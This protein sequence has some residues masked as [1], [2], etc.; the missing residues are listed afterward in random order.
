MLSRT[1]TVGTLRPLTGHE[2]ETVE[3]ALEM[4]A[5]SQ[6]KL[7]IAAQ[8]MMEQSMPYNLLWNSN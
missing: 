3:T 2:L 7:A 4:L 8:G 5:K 1:I 6:D